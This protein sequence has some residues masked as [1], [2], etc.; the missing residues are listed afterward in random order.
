NGPLDNILKGECRFS[1]GPVWLFGIGNDGLAREIIGRIVRPGQ[2][3]ILLS[4][5]PLKTNI[6]FLSSTTVECAGVSAIAVTMPETVTV[7]DI[8]E[9]HKLGIQVAR[10]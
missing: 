5:E 4:R 1:S 6:G 9:L 8:A 3:Y 7:E 10:N 2:R